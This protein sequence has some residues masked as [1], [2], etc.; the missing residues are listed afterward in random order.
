MFD[1]PELAGCCTIPAANIP[2]HGMEAVRKTLSF[3]YRKSE[4]LRQEV[5]FKSSA[6]SLRD[7][8]FTPTWSNTCWGSEN[9]QDMGRDALCIN[10][11]LTIFSMFVTFDIKSQF[12]YKI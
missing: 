8:A 7:E 12:F 11:I 10:P 6:S 3:S 2:G 1:H 5:F 9:C 4:D